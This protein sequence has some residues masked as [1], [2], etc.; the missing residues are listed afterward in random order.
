M[1]PITLTFLVIGGIGLVLLLVAL[2]V[3]ELGHLGDVG[4]ADGPFSLPAMAAL[5]G[6]G[7]FIGAIPASLLS[8]SLSDTTVVLISAAIGLVGALP[9]AWGAIRLT[10]GLMRMKTDDTLSEAGVA[11]ATGVVITPIPAT[12]FGEVRI[13]LNGQ[14]LKF[15][16]RAAEPLPLGTPIYVTQA[17]SA[18]AV[19]VLSTAERPALPTTEES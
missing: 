16:A 18:S 14:P 8:D 6:G 17:L 9:L 3:G 19:E 4:D 11:G 15:A 10:R 7:G 5:I 1:D 2:F 12:G 13:R